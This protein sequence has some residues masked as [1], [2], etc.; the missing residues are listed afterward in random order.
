MRSTNGLEILFRHEKRALAVIIE[1]HCHN[2]QVIMIG[3]RSARSQYLLEYLMRTR[4]GIS[5]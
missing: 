2:A 5:R 1:I 4:L 3:R